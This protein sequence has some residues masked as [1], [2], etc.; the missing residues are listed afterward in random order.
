[1]PA[2]C[3]GSKLNSF[4]IV[5]ATAGALPQCIHYKVLGLCYWLTCSGLHCVI[6]P[7]IKLAH[8]SP[9]VV[10]SVYSQ[11]GDNP[12]TEASL[13][14]DKPAEY[15]AKKS[16]RK[17]TGY[18]LG[19]GKH[20]MGSRYNN[21]VHFYEVDIVGNPATKIFGKLVTLPSQAKPWKHYFN[22]S[23]D[24]LSWRFGLEWL[25]PTS[26]DNSTPTDFA[27]G[28]VSPHDGF[29]NQTEDVKAAAVIATRAMDIITNAHKFHVYTQL[30][31]KSCGKKCEA[32]NPISPRHP[33]PALWQMLYPIAD[34][35]CKAFGR[36]E[37]ITP[38]IQTPE[39]AYTWNLW[40]YYEGCLDGHGI[41]IGSTHF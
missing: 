36:D 20:S 41:Y 32:I 38:R 33:H 2:V 27:W 22:S 28:P 3:V 29:I 4:S 10:V 7:T 15:L 30:N 11:M 8:Y 13:V 23:L 26:K 6:E 31:K 18:P 37:S 1:M 40:R 17:L 14:Y 12:W 24:V 5:A 19:G 34:T 16:T 35:N 25:E 9:D 39:D 21:P